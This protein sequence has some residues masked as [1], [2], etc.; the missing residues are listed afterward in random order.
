MVE[1]VIVNVPVYCTPKDSFKVSTRLGNATIITAPADLIGFL[2]QMHCNT[3]FN[4][5]ITIY[6]LHRV[7]SNLLTHR[8]RTTFAINLSSTSFGSL[9][10]I[11]TFGERTKPY[12]LKYS[13]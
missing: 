3:T 6:F 9:S 13:E 1:T 5:R 11:A 8:V 4:Y 12:T 2:V 10:L 7:H